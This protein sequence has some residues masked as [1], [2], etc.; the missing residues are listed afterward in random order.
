[1]DGPPAR[2]WDMLLAPG[3]RPQ[4]VAHLVIGPAE[5]V[6]A[7]GV[8]KAARWPRAAFHAPVILFQVV[9]FELGRAVL[10]RIPEYLREGR[11]IAGVL[12]RR[13]RVGCAAGSLDGGAEESLGGDL[14]AVFAEVNVDQSAV[15]VDRPVQLSCLPSR[16]LATR[17]HPGCAQA[18]VLGIPT[19]GGGAEDDG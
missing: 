9:V 19:A 13:D 10:G 2:R 6:G 5:A 15:G 7:V 11:R 17:V 16:D 18:L 8:L 1:M 4:K 14:V 12:V 3:W